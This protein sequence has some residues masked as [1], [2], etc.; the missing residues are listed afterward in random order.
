MSN[1]QY[2]VTTELGYALD[3]FPTLA[4]AERHAEPLW[5]ETVTKTP[6]SVKYADDLS[7]WMEN[8]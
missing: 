1:I 4:A 3:S 5:G 2:T 6:L 7:E 8:E